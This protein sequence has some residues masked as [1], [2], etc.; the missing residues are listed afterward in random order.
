MMW[1]CALV[2]Q[3]EVTRDHGG[4]GCTTTRKGGVTDDGVSFQERGTWVVISGGWAG[5]VVVIDIHNKGT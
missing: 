4:I 3:N 2:K 5:W 1:M